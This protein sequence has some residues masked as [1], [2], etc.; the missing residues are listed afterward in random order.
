VSTDDDNH[1][2]RLYLSLGIVAGSLMEKD[3]MLS[4]IQALRAG[5][6]HADYVRVVRDKLAQALDEAGKA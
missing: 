4:L 5:D 3:R 6:I 2:A 1:M